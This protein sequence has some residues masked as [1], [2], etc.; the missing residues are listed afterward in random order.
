MM[1]TV[2]LKLIHSALG[3]GQAAVVENLE[4]DVEDFRMR[5]LYLVEEDDRVRSVAH[6]FGEGEPFSKPT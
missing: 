5:L 1:M 3:I 4:E 6:R 2:F